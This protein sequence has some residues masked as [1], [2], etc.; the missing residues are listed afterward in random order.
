MVSAHTFFELSCQMMSM[1]SVLYS[2][3]TLWS[4]RLAL[5]TCS[6]VSRIPRMHTQFS[7]QG[8]RRHLFKRL[9]LHLQD[10]RS[11]PSLAVVLATDMIISSWNSIWVEALEYGVWGTR[12]V[13]GLF[14]ALAKP[15]F[16]DKACPHC[17]NI[18]P[19]SYPEHLFAKHLIDYNLGGG[20]TW[21]NGNTLVLYVRCHAPVTHR[22]TYH[23][24]GV[25]WQP[26]GRKCTQSVA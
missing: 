10:F 22:K 17:D 9:E 20:C 6:Y 5:V 19:A 18:I 3:A 14:G 21:K 24:H 7:V 11:H 12:L 23:L 13:Q 2:S 1:R 26:G 16:R 15:T 4:N 8:K 25:L